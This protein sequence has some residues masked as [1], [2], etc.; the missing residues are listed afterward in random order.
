MHFEVNFLLCVCAY[1]CRALLLAA[2]NCSV[3]ALQLFLLAER[4]AQDLG[5]ALLLRC[6]GGDGSNVLNVV[7]CGATV[8][9]L[10]LLVAGR[11]YLE[12]QVLVL[13]IIGKPIDYLA[14]HHASSLIHTNRQTISLSI[15]ALS[16]IH[17]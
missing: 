6:A 16:L 7:C 1:W 11:F 9:L 12:V 14:V 15:Y 2:C 10:S 17:I 8:I 13:V 4:R 5:I 3:V